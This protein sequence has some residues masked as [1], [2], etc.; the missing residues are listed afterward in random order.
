[1]EFIVGCIGVWLVLAVIGGAVGVL[2][3]GVESDP[4]Q[5]RK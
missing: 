1:M 3:D 5:K 2:S 4:Y